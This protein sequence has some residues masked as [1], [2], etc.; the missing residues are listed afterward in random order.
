MLRHADEFG[1]LQ[2]AIGTAAGGMGGL[3]GGMQEQANQNLQAEA[4]V[5]ACEQELKNTFIKAFSLFVEGK[6][7]TVK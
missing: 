4:N 6:G 1:N 5:A 7:Y 3:R 2:Q